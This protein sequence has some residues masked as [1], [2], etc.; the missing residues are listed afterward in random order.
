MGDDAGTLRQA[1]LGGERR[2]VDEAADD[3]GE[4][5]GGGVEVDVLV[6]RADVGAAPFV[7]LSHKEQMHR[8]VFHEGLRVAEG[9]EVFVVHLL[10]GILIGLVNP[11]AGGGEEVER[12]ILLVASGGYGALAGGVFAPCHPEDFAEGLVV[13]RFVLIV[14]AAGLAGVDRLHEGHAAC[15]D[16]RG[17]LLELATPARLAE[18]HQPR[19]KTYGS[20]FHCIPIVAYL[21]LMASTYT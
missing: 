3:G 4:A 16:R 21:R 13:Y 17:Q 5:F 12:H 20:L 8:G 7:V 10:K 19:Q 15:D 14:Q 6:G 1:E 9:D 2:V 18:S 11:C